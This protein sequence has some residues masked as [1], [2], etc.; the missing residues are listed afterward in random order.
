MDTLFEKIKIRKIV[1]VY[2]SAVILTFIILQMPFAKNA[3]LK[4]KYFA[5]VILNILI[6]TWF[7][8]IFSKEN[9]SVKSKVIHSIKKVNYKKIVKLY[10]LNLGIYIGTGLCIFIGDK[11]LTKVPS[12]MF[13]IFGIT[14]APIVEELIFRGVAMGRLKIR[15]GI[16][17]AIFVSAIIFGIVHF[18]FNILG[19]LFFG[20]LSAILYIETKNIMNCIIFHIL[21]NASVFIFPTI[22]QHTN[23]LINTDSEFKTGILILIIFSC[24]ISAIVFNVVYVKNNLPRKNNMS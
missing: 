9:V 21:H 5:E 18:D 22:S 4:D 19:R 17:P 15:L 24:F 7:Y 3:Y 11:P 13:I 20:V 12:D 2:F 8:I 10:I 14:L 23:F 16:I 6:L 1:L